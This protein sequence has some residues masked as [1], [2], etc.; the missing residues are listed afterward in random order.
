MPFAIKK[1]I[2][3]SLSSQYEL[4]FFSSRD[5]LNIIKLQTEELG[6]C[7]LSGTKYRK[8]NSWMKFLKEKESK[9]YRERF[10]N[11]TDSNKG[12]IVFV[13]LNTHLVAKI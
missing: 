12:C 11:E 4:A 5:I 1:I 9:V 6:E 8:C 10:V 7:L 13:I 2:V 3:T